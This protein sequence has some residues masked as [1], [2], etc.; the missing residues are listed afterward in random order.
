MEEIEHFLSQYAIDPKEKGLVAVSFGP[1]SMALLHLLLD[2]GFSNLEVLHINH[3]LRKESIQEEKLLKEHL[4]SIGLPYHIKRLDGKKPKNNFEDYYREKRHEIFLE[5]YR[6]I[7]A[8]TLFLGHQKDEQA[9]TILKRLL[10]GGD[11]NGFQGI[12]ENHSLKGMKIARPLLRVSKERLIDYLKKKGVPFSI[13]QSNFDPKYLRGR[14]RNT[15]IPNLEASFQKQ[16]CGNLI[17]FSSLM[18]KLSLYLNTRVEKILNGAIR[19]PYGSFYCA[20]LINALHEVELWQFLQHLGVPNRSLKEAIISKI[21][22]GAFGLCFPLK[23]KTL[24]LER[25]GLF[26]LENPIIPPKMVPV[27]GLKRGW[28]SFWRGEFG[29]HLPY[30]GAKLSLPS[31]K[32][33]VGKKELNKIY[34]EANIPIF[35]RK[36]CYVVE[37]EGKIIH[38]FLSL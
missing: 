19:G 37:S 25:V 9:E 36:M 32:S 18:T 3:G 13:D 14:M 23:G 30:E 22:K 10:E 20:S 24:Y 6:E 16:I 15:I 7:N 12:K 4:E 38:E 35:L 11:W 1:D 34:S 28:R 26:I 29:Y 27:Q 31:L 33:R 5:V 17:G 21:Q 2:L 8:N